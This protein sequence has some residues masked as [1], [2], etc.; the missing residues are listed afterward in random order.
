[1]A[2]KIRDWEVH[3]ERDRTKQW[4]ALSW[5]PVPNKQGSGYRKS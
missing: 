4:K 5:V 3:F 2:I 1:M